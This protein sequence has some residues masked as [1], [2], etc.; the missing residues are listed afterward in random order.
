MRKEL[1]G[2]GRLGRVGGREM[3]IGDGV[4]VDFGGVGYACMRQRWLVV[5]M[6]T[7]V[8]MER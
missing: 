5:C 4:F 8:R 1:W 6:V 3:G 7:L 2:G